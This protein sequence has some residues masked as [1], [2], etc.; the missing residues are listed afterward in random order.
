MGAKIHDMGS[1]LF[2][3]HCPGC[4][5]GHCFRAPGW[6]WNG[7]A[8]KPT[9]TPS[10]LTNKDDPKSRCHVVV[11]DGKLNFCPDS[12]HQLAGKVVDMVDWDD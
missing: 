4:G 10:L 8:E 3:F 12:Y 7:S 1:N 2:A 6:S 5:R 11:T 9:V